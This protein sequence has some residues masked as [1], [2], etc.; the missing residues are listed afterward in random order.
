MSATTAPTTGEQG[1]HGPGSYAA[2]IITSS[3]SEG[4]VWM[5]PASPST[6]RPSP[7]PLRREHPERHRH[8]DGP[9]QGHAHEEQVLT[10][11]QPHPR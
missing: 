6:P 2:I 7:R 5:T 10:R 11:A 8:D 1:H 9:E 4:T 3:A